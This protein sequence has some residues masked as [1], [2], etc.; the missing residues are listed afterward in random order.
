M[1]KTIYELDLHE[2]VFVGNGIRATRVPGGWIY[3]K[4]GQ[5]T[6]VPFC[7]ERQ[8]EAT[9]EKQKGSKSEIDNVT[10]EEVL[11]S[12]MGLIRDEWNKYKTFLK[13]K[14]PV[15]EGD[16]WAL[17]CDYHKRIDELIKLVSDIDE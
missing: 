6:F 3:K 13:S 1:E 17:T 8:T 7:D 14:Y 2:E 9:Y 12:L 16:Q 11:M 4:S 5:S 10:V 15:R